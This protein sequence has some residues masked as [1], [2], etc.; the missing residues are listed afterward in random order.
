[1][2]LRIGVSKNQLCMSMKK[3]RLYCNYF[4]SIVTMQSIIVSTAN[5][6]HLIAA[7]LV[8]QDIALDAPTDAEHLERRVAG[9]GG[10]ANVRQLLG[11]CGA[12][13]GAQHLIHLAAAAVAVVAVSLVG[14][15]GDAAA[16]RGGY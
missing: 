12:A 10:E 5:I 1:M 2:Q 16:S 14:N 6:T 13:A 8:P 4:D 15:D 9:R 3:H 11:L 7:E